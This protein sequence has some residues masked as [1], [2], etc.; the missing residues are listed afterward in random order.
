MPLNHIIRKCTESYKFVN[1]PKSINKLIYRDG[2]KLLAKKKKK[3]KKLVS[4]TNFK[5]IQSGFRN[6]FWHWK[7]CHAKNGNGIK[8]NNG[9]DTAA[10]S[11]KK[12]NVRRKGNLRLLRN[13]LA[14]TISG[15]ERKI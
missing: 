5:Y 6:R 13:F 8:R 14:E 11:R 12:P 15:D 1:L 9:R 3:K 2:I 4:N 10:E 7:M